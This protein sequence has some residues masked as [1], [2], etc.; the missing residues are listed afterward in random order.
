M[1]TIDHDANYYGS[2]SERVYRQVRDAIVRGR[3]RPGD[4]L[5]EAELAKRFGVSRTPVRE[6]L[7]WLAHEGFAVAESLAR[8]TQFVV[9]PLNVSHVSE[10][11]GIIGSLERY[12]AGNVAILESA[13]RNELIEDLKHLNQDL[14]RAS[15]ARPRDPELLFHLQTAFHIRFVYEA[16]DRRFREIYDIVR[17]HVQRY[18]WVYGTLGESNYGP[19]IHEHARIISA[20]TTGDRNGAQNAV[21]AHWQRAAARTTLMIGQMENRNYSS[22]QKA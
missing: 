12:Q 14:R 18:E 3:I 5:I 8:R 13:R 6:A 10:Y 16:S 4:R 15:I 11:W 21:E 7:A 1:T 20:I 17:A 19:S 2:L 22:K 9:A